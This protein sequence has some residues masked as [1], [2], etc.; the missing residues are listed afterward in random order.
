MRFQSLLIVFVTFAVA[1]FALPVEVQGNSAP[2]SCSND[3]CT[4]SVTER[5]GND[6]GVTDA[7]DNGDYV[8]ARMAVPEPGCVAK[9]TSD[10]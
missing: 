5:D 9:R 1:T 6:C 3:I 8:A 4:D 2:D 10:A 7:D